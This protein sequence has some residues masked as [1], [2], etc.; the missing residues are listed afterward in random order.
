[1]YSVGYATGFFVTALLIVALITQFFLWLLKHWNASVP[2]LLVANGLSLFVISLLNAFGKADGGEPKFQAA[3]ASF[4]IPQLAWLVIGLVRDGRKVRRVEKGEAA[5]AV[6][7]NSPSSQSDA[8]ATPLSVALPSEAQVALSADDH[9]APFAAPQELPK[10]GTEK[11]KANF[12]ARHWRGELPLW[13]SYWVF[14]FLANIVATIFVV[15]VSGVLSEGGDYNP[16]KILIVLVSIWVG[17][18]LIAVWQLVGI[19][20]SADRHVSRK[21]SRVWAGLAKIAVVLGI[22]RMVLEFGQVGYPQ[23]T[24]TVRMAFFDDPD[25]PAY[26]IRIMRNGTEVEV[27]GGF[28]YGLNDDFVRIL[29]AAPQVKV[30]HLNSDGGRLGEAE[31]L[32]NTIRKL[33]L[34]TYTSRRC[35][36]ACT[37]AFMAGRERWI[38]PNGRL[39]FHAPTFPGMGASDAAEASSS[40]RKFMIEAGVPSEFVSRALATP[41]STMWYPTREELVTARA[42]TGVADNYKFAVSGWGAN[43]GRAEIEE[44]LLKV[45]SVFAALKSARPQDFT[46][47]VDR[48]TNGYLFGESEGAVI[49]AARAQMLPI[50][51]QY[52]PLADDQTILDQ[53]RLLLDQ[54]KALSAVDKQLCYE[55]ASGVDATKNYVAY[56]PGPMRQREVEL[57]ERILKTATARETVSAKA[58]EPLWSIVGGQLAKRFGANEIELLTQG[59]LSPS[60]RARY[61]D[62]AIAMYEEM[63]NLPMSSAVQVLRDNFQDLAKGGP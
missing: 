34:S 59:N 13:V 31:K 39:G 23:I 14:G 41:N 3:F 58:A 38:H 47:M 17:I 30:V 52:R 63:L 60:H 28:K 8:N 55:Y 57:S 26:A 62:L 4:A 1:M 11:P 29:K 50:I 40:Q 61:C 32:Y 24:E 5:A 21:G 27:S 16:T 7:A 19:W 49:D 46:K 36:S 51:I 54:Y 12:I 42:A 53:G 25:I 35:A 6:P 9:S 43:V 56:L 20:R 37:M 10:R 15:A 44:Q 2:R 33:G 48:V 22:L 45:G 18:G